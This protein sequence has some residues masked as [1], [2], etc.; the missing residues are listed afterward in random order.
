MIALILIP[1][2]LAGPWRILANTRLLDP[3]MDAGVISYTDMDQGFIRGIPDITDYLRSQEDV[4]WNLVLLCAVIYL[5]FYVIKSVQFH[6]IG[7]LYGLKGGYS[8][9]ARAYFYGLGINRLLPFNAGD[10]ATVSVCHGQGSR[11]RAAASTLYV[12]DMFVWFEIAFF[13]A[14]GIILT[15]WSQAFGQSLMAIIFFAALYFIT[16][17]ARPS[18]MV[19]GKDGKPVRASLRAF[20]TLANDPLLLVRLGCLSLLAFFLDDITP[21]VTSQAFTE[22]KVMLNVGFLV[23]QGGVV[24]GYIASRPA[25][26]PG[27]IGQFEFGFATALVATGLALPDAISIA[28]LD[29]AIRHSVAFVLFFSVKLS[30]GVETNFRTV[31]DRL[32]GRV[33]DV[34]DEP[35]TGPPIDAES[36]LAGGPVV[37]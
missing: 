28:L 20:L 22:G 33:V 10:V 17:S 30:K 9:H 6:N 21:Y 27:G 26:T 34:D 19:T 16:R 12:Q 23:I 3:L 8:D 29:G 13:F 36:G 15:G 37:T 5:G 24:A 11:A 25:I 4:A 31:L 7:K 14:L 32:L 35:S 18:H 1:V 2:I